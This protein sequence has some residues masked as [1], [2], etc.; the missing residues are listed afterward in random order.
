MSPLWELQPALGWWESLCFHQRSPPSIP[1]GEDDL[2]CTNS[3]RVLGQ[4]LFCGRQTLLLRPGLVLCFCRL[5]TGDAR[6]SQL[7]PSSGQ[8]AHVGIRRWLKQE[9]PGD[10]KVFFGCLAGY[11]TAQPQPL[12][13]PPPACMFGF[14]P[15]KALSCFSG[16]QPSFLM[17]S[18]RDNGQ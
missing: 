5:T 1:G 6:G 14:L 8:G 13:A 10:F 18:S 3:W 9:G 2:G 11:S 12:L 16:S 17:E 15:K 7:L 4:N